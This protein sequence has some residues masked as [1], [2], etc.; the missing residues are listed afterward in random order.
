MQYLSLASPPQR[1]L[2]TAPLPI[3]YQH[4]FLQGWGTYQPTAPK[5]ANCSAGNQYTAVVVPGSA[6]SYH[7]IRARSPLH[8]ISPARS[9]SRLT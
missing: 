6:T 2:L 8:R 9:G 7:G 4:L 3:W 5:D 1:N